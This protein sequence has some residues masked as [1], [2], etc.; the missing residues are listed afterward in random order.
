MQRQEASVDEIVNPLRFFERS[1]E[2]VSL[3][4]LIVDQCAAIGLSAKRSRVCT[5]FRLAM[6]Y[7]GPLVGDIVSRKLV[8][9]NIPGKAE[10]SQDPNPIPVKIELI[11]SHTMTS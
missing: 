3:P 9:F 4:N 1:A 5:A 6:V 8:R 10:H 2:E 11:P 7:L